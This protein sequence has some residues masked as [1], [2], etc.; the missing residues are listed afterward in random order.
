MSRKRQILELL[1]RDELLVALDA[2]EIEAADRRAKV[3]LVDALSRSKKASIAEILE[4]MPR[5]R[6]KELCT[7]LGHD[8]GREKAVLVERLAVAAPAHAAPAASRQSPQRSRI[9][10]GASRNG[11]PAPECR[12]NG[13]PTVES[14]ERRRHPAQPEPTAN[15][16][17]C[18]LPGAHAVLGAPPQ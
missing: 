4:P 9:G 14:L 16:R 10:N 5:V 7:K 15:M 11:A 18:N 1:T 2:Y 3:G 13:T 6:L 12:A 17:V 8:S